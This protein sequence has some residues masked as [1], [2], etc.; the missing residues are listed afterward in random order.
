MSETPGKASIDQ[1][2]RQ[3]STKTGMN[4]A[5]VAALLPMATAVPMNGLKKCHAAGRRRSAGKGADKT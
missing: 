2:T 3:A 4:K 1:M 5:A